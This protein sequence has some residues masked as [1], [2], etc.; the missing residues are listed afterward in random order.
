M[1]EEPELKE[2]DYSE[3]GESPYEEG[4]QAHRDGLDVTDNPYDRVRQDVPYE[5]WQRGWM[6][7][8][9]GRL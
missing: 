6:D 1:S 7:A 8:E 9:E 2:P 3:E 4:R 5:D